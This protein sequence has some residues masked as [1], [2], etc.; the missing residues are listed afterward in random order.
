MVSRSGAAGGQLRKAAASSA[1]E[2]GAEL[3]MK[4]V[5]AAAMKRSSYHGRDHSD[6]ADCPPMSACCQML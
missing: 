5:K 1:A 2:A 6:E 3:G 4:V